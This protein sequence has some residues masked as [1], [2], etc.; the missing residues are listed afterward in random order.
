MEHLILS[1]LESRLEEGGL[2][3]GRFLLGPFRIGQGI[4]V[5]TALRRTL[6]S[7]L[8]GIAITAVEIDG[9]THQYSSIVGVQESALD[10]TLNL[11]QVVL[12]GKGITELPAIG[13]INVLGPKEV[14][15]K[16]L[17]LPNGILCVNKNQHIAT[18]SSNGTLTMKFL[19]SSGK[20]YITHHLAPAQALKPSLFRPKERSIV[21]SLSMPLLMPQGAKSSPPSSFAGLK[22]RIDAIGYDSRHSTRLASKFVLASG[23]DLNVVSYVKERRFATSFFI[24]R[25]DETGKS[26]IP[27]YLEQNQLTSS[28]IEGD[29]APS[30]STE[31][32]VKPLQGGISVQN[33]DANTLSKAFPSVLKEY[34]EGEAVGAASN[35][36]SDNGNNYRLQGQLGLPSPQLSRGRSIDPQQETLLEQKGRKEMFFAVLAEESDDLN[37]KKKNNHYIHHESALEPGSSNE[38][39]AFFDVVSDR[40]FLPIDAVFM[41]INSVNFSLQTDDQWQEPKERVIVEIWTNGSVS[42]R[43]AL[44]EAATCLAYTFSLF[45]QPHTMSPFKVSLNIDARQERPIHRRESVSSEASVIW[46]ETEARRKDHI[47]AT[48]QKNFPWKQGNLISKMSQGV[49]WPPPRWPGVRWPPPAIEGVA[50]EPLAIEGEKTDLGNLR[51]SV[52]AYMALKQSKIDTVRDLLVCSPKYLNKVVN[53]NKDLYFEVLAKI[54]ELDF[55]R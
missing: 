7:E 51:L 1:C 38:S 4:T 48:G 32:A 11:K 5:A 46:E 9:A 31:P 26:K 43:Q 45:R 50:N 12:A 22:E 35:L 34:R 54:K 8:Q 47:A 40:S 41:P 6:L 37:V 28:G 30:G 14:C 10:I 25:K 52:P 55:E 3:Y 53:G 21:R 13:Y 20:G 29:F 15:G 36:R 2:L 44:H 18:I 49:R 16:D 42:P 19:I 33:K 24:R 39:N 27:L 23:A 17:R